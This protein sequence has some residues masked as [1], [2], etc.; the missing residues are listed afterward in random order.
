M[1]NN[2]IYNQI[3]SSLSILFIISI[4]V[5]E[6][7]NIIQCKKITQELA[8][9]AAFNKIIEKANFQYNF[10]TIE[11]TLQMNPEFNSYNDFEKYSIM[12]HFQK[13]FRYFARNENLKNYKHNNKMEIFATSDSSSYTFK[14][15]FLHKKQPN[16]TKSILYK[17]QKEIYSSLYLVGR[18]KVHHGSNNVSE[19]EL[20]VLQFAFYT[21]RILT[22][23]GKYYSPKT[24]PQ[25]IVDIVCKKYN[26][27]YNV[28][29]EET[30]NTPI[31]C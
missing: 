2:K 11:I 31:F 22:N 8:Q 27:T 20:E 13:Q 9:S 4:C 29:H 30:V 12:E 14:N 26:L 1:K 18:N 23:N 24:D 15:S 3:S 5:F 6:G 25:I 7:Y 19:F 10:S 16:K 28:I 21:F 17:D